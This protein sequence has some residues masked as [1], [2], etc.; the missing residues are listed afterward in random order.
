MGGMLDFFLEFAIVWIIVGL[1]ITG[2]MYVAFNWIADYM[3]TPEAQQ[4]LTAEDI[5]AWQS[6]QED[7]EASLFFLMFIGFGAS[8]GVIIQFVFVNFVTWVVGTF[9]GGSGMLFTFLRGTL[10]WDI[11]II[12]ISLVGLIL[13]AYL[14]SSEPT[15]ATWTFLGVGALNLIFYTPIKGWVVGNYHEIG[16]I[17]GIFALI[18]AGFVINACPFVLALIG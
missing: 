15:Y 18:G 9:F 3:N 5:E 4:E 2:G 6:I 8:F 17:Q 11:G 16:F 14:L 10:R 7:A 13:G 1:V 12:A